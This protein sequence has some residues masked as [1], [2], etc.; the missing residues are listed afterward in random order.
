[1]W[2]RLKPLRLLSSYSYPPPSGRLDEVSGLHCIIPNGMSAPGNA[3]TE[4]DVPMN[5]LTSEAG[6]FAGLR[7][8]AELAPAVTTVLSAPPRATSA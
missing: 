4:P 5:G 6:S 1:M 2:V 3:S 8:E 7:A